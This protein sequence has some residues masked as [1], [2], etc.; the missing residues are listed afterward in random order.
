VPLERVKHNNPALAGE[1]DDRPGGQ[2]T[3]DIRAVLNRLAPSVL[4]KDVDTDPT[5]PDDEDEDQGDVVDGGQ[6]GKVETGTL[7]V[8]PRRADIDEERDGVSDDSDEDD[9][10]QNVNMKDVDDALKL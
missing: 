9:D 3:A 6:E 2:E 7:T 8:Q 10:R 1:A 4:V 5:E